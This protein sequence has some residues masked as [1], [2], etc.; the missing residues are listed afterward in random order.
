M[1]MEEEESPLVYYRSA[2]YAAPRSRQPNVQPGYLCPY[3]CGRNHLNTGDGYRL[4]GWAGEMEA[5]S[6]L[7]L[8]KDTH[9][10]GEAKTTPTV[11]SLLATRVG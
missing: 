4:G 1:S 2:C 11:R 7:G 8:Q 9:R 5:I 6:S 3:R 10:N